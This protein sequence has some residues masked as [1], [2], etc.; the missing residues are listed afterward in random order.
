[1]VVD[2]VEEKNGHQSLVDVDVV[3]F[4]VVEVGGG[5]WRWGG[6]NQKLVLHEKLFKKTHTFLK[7]WNNKQLTVLS[8]KLISS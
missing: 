6:R 1:M 7:S 5:W 2:G 4:V 8:K 3:E